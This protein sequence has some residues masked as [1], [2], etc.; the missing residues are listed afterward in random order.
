[1]GNTAVM[2]LN[3]NGAAMLRRYLP[4]VV[5][6]TPAAIADVIVVDN[7]NEAAVRELMESMAGERAVY[8]GSKTNLGG[9]GGFAL[10]RG[11]F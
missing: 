8:I 1:M 10:G 4:E 7:G 5:R 6:T 9:A 2:I 3:W 11:E